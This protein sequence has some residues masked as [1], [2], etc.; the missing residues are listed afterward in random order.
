MLTLMF[1]VL[2][3]I[4]QIFWSWINTVKI[5][6]NWVIIHIIVLFPQPPSMLSFSFAH[7]S[8]LS[9]CSSCI[10]TLTHL[11]FCENKIKA[12]ERKVLE[13]VLERRGAL[14]SLVSPSVSFKL[15]KRQ[16]KSTIT[17][18]MPQTSAINLEIQWSKWT[19]YPFASICVFEAF[20]L[21]WLYSI[22]SLGSPLVI[23][24]KSHPNC[25]V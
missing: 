20:K 1:S 17:K 18:N 21:T 14:I 12:Y 3:V 19:H 22:I 13:M 25:L 23:L 10:A 11:Y 7:F 9:C 4:T 24:S 5:T 2:G 6:S 8:L 15:T 16:K